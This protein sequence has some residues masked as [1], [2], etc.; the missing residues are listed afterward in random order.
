MAESSIR[1]F[2]R[3]EPSRGAP[4]KAADPE[5]PDMARHLS[6]RIDCTP[7]DGK[8]SKGQAHPDL[9]AREKTKRV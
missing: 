3:T 4:S 6:R 9:P 2:P 1:E 8:Q 5:T 7:S